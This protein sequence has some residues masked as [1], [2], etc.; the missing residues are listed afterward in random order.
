[1]GK[2]T[3]NG[4]SANI[5]QHFLFA[6]S[7]S[8]PSSAQYINGPSSSPLMDDQ[9]HGCA[10]FH[11][12]KKFGEK[13]SLKSRFCAVPLHLSSLKPA[14]QEK[15]VVHR[16]QAV[17]PKEYKRKFQAKKQGHKKA[18]PPSKERVF[19]LGGTNFS[20]DEADDKEFR[21]NSD[22]PGQRPLHLALNNKTKRKRGATSQ[23]QKRQ[24]DV[25][26]A[27]GNVERKRHR[28]HR[29][30]GNQD[31]DQDEE[32]DILAALAALGENIY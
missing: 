13:G 21:E 19:S 12:C 3:N 23:D 5:P 4:V 7:G 8:N 18:A 11:I 20:F 9:W 26:K 22:I 27:S 31:D 14:K 24:L 17:K 28:K 32:N 25:K 2:W 1:M 29:F 10:S 16:P 30:F 15:L 6:V